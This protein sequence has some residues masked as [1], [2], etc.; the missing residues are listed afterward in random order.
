MVLIVLPVYGQKSFNKEKRKVNTL[1]S[2]KDRDSLLKKHKT[3]QKGNFRLEI[4]SKESFLIL[5]VIENE[6]FTKL[7]GKI[8]KGNIKDI[9]TTGVKF[10]C[11]YNLPVHL[12]IKVEICFKIA[13]KEFRFNA[14]IVRKDEHLSRK[15]KNYGIKFI[16][17]TSKEQENL[18]I[19]LRKL[20]AQQ[21]RKVTSVSS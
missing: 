9:S 15:S 11:P 1:T 4:P 21:R 17:I 12:K 10:I 3:K 13:S 14:Y 18:I 8:V 6:D 20:E 5:K 2:Q 19:E 7:I 16:E